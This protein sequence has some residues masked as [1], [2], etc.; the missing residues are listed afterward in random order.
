MSDEQGKPFALAVKALVADDRGRLLAIRRSMD[1]KQFK[2]AWDLPGGKVD[3]E[4]AF[5][6]ALVREVLE[7]TGLTVA[8]D[9]VAGAVQYDSPT[10]RLAVLVL[11]ARL[12]RGQVTLSSEHDDFAWVPPAELA[13]L[14]F[15]GELRNFV[16][17]YCRR[18]TERPNQ[19]PSMNK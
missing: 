9:S 7:E 5:D 17:D 18:L 12:V 14:D 3:P 4:E 8:I 1:S 10:L 19:N 15:R 13:A 11:G 6:V 16:V 2:H